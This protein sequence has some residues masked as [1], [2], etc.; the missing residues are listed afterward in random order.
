[1]VK[2]NQDAM[3]INSDQ[4]NEIFTIASRKSK[5]EES[6]PGS[7]TNISIDAGDNAIEAPF[8]FKKGDYYYLFASIDYCCRGEKSTYKMIVGRSKDLSGPYLGKEGKQMKNGGG[9]I[10]LQGNKNWYGV[11]HN[12]VYNFMNEDYLI[13]HA[14]DAH[15]EGKPVLRI[16]KLNWDENLWPIPDLDSELNC[17]E[18]N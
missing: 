12:S 14:Y 13:F 5:P 15:W 2:L 10:L 11:G 6:N 9:S 8:I 16:L 1:M 18:V 17:K 4:A 7:S 3:S